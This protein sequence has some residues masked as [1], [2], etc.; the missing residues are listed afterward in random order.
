LP[1]GESLVATLSAHKERSQSNGP[2]DSVFGTGSR[3]IEYDVSLRKL[4][5]AG[6]R[7][8]I[9]WISWHELRRFFANIS[10]EFG[11]P[12]ADRQYL[13]GHSSAAMTQHYTT[14]PEIERKRPYVERISRALL[15]T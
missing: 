7:A 9:P 1:L 8:G 2:D 14:T 12:L 10:D 4:K 11:I 5:K 13:M 6:K 15:D 3:P